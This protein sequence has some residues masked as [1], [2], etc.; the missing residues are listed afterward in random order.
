MPD[1]HFLNIY[2]TYLNNDKG[3]YIRG[4]ELA[5][6]KTFD[7]LPGMLGGLGATAS[8][9]YTESE[10]EVSGGAFYG[11]DLPLPGLSENVWSTTV[12]FDYERFS[13]HVNVRYR[14]EFVQ[15]L[16]IPGAGSPTLAQPYTTVDAQVSYAF[17]NGLSIVISGNN[18]TDESNIIEYGVDNAFGEYKQFGRQYYFGINY[19]Y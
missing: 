6:T 16:P 9:S 13:S 1:G 4:V 7:A 19:K 3:G 10:T 11:R 18:L 14:D 12:F 5:A 17:E 15:N 8:Y 2:Q